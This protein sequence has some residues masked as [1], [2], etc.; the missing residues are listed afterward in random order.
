VDSGEYRAR[1]RE[2][3]EVAETTHDPVARAQ[4]LVIASQ[5]DK[6]AER[7]EARKQDTRPS[8]H[9]AK[10]S[11]TGKG[12]WLGDRYGGKCPLAGRGSGSRSGPSSSLMRAGA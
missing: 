10:E 1:A 4:L 12:R 11:P 8:N 5:Y 7:A 3:C 2:L 9:S 6:L